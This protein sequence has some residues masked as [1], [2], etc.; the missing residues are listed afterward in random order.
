MNEKYMKCAIEQA[1][2]AFE[3]G[4]VPVGCIIVYNDEIIGR[5]FNK[6]NKN[7]TVLA[8]A[9]MEAINEAC[10][11]INDWRLEECIIYVTVEP[12]PM[13][14]GAIL[15]SRIKKVVFGAR[16]PKAG[17]CGSILNIVNDSRFNHVVE[18]EEGIL[19]EECSEIMKLFFK[20][21]REEFKKEKN[22]NSIDNSRL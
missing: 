8:H 14:A 12:C 11:V 19:A 2:K 17:C 18:I 16:N 13:C 7:K 3:A 6:R 10:S 15:Q 4:E 21:K 5:G 9:E 1:H 20:M 22:E